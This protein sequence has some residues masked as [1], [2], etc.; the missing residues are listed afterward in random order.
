M[1]FL[2]W[3][4]KLRNFNEN[5]PTTD[6]PTTHFYKFSLI[7]PTSLK[8]S[9]LIGNLNGN[10]PTRCKPSVLYENLEKRKLWK[11]KISETEV[12]YDGLH[13]FLEIIIWCV[14]LMV[15]ACTV[16]GIFD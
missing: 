7:F 13:A 16:T 14:A 3:S 15:C 12:D 4:G 11:M 6:F 9:N 10:F 1:K 2:V 5:F 8:L